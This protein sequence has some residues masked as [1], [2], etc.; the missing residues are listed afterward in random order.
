MP[1]F[2]IH[3]LQIFMRISIFSCSNLLAQPPAHRQ[4]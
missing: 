4:G 2:R 3:S 1:N